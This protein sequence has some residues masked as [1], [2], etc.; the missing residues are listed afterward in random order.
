MDIHILVLDQIIIIQIGFLKKKIACARG[1]VEGKIS[2]TPK[3][4]NGFD[5]DPIF[6]PNKSKKTFAE[7]NPLQKYRLDPRYKSFKKIKKFL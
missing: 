2:D 3:G 1:I 4:K 5:Y 6:I 7:M